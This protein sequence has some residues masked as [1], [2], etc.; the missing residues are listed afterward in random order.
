[1]RNRSI[2]FVVGLA[3]TLFSF[4]LPSL[5]LSSAQAS[6]L[7]TFEVNNTVINVRSIPSIDGE[8]VGQLEKGDQLVA[9]DEQYGWVQTYYAGKEVWVAKYLLIAKSSNS[10]SSPNPTLNQS[11]DLEGYNIII[12]PGHGGKDPGAIGINNIQEKE[13]VFSTSLKVV[14]QLQNHGA[15]VITTR[16]NDN[17][18]SLEDRVRISN[19]YNTHVFISIHYNAAINHSANGITTYIRDNLDRD[20]GQSIQEAMISSVTLH[21]RGVRQADFKVLRDTEAPSALLEL[22]FITNFTDLSIVQTEAYQE[23]IAEGITNGV[24]DYIE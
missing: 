10:P 20:L 13:L 6:S 19:S 5:Q 4:L 7:E 2:I 14:E 3:V 18:I 22:G 17:F 15:T 9:F 21:D 12:D 23:S 11:T 24:L 1:M 16:A 8:I